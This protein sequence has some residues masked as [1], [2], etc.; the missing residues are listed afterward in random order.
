ML[1][2]CTPAVWIEVPEYAVLTTT[3]AHPTCDARHIGARSRKPLYDPGQA[4]FPRPVLASALH[5]MCQ[6]HAFLSQ[7]KLWSL[8]S[9]P[10]TRVSTKYGVSAHQGDG[11]G[12]WNLCAERQEACEHDAEGVR[13]AM[14][15]RGIT[16]YA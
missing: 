7:V 9:L 3:Y 1:I 4:A 5:A 15:P 10:S 11:C 6:G 16:S 13:T 2:R 14:R 12:R 8:A